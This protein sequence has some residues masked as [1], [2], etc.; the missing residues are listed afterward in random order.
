MKKHVI[1]LYL[2]LSDEDDREFQESNSITSQR[3]ILTN[4]VRNH[5]EFADYRAVEFCDDGYSGTI[6]NT[7]R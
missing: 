6:L 2:R 4:Y 5:K 7:V 1:G 3:E